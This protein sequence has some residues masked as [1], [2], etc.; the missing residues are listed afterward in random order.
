MGGGAAA[1]HAADKLA[2]VCADGTPAAWLARSLGPGSRAAACPVAQRPA[3][4][5]CPKDKLAVVRAA[6]DVLGEADVWVCSVSAFALAESLW[7]LSMFSSSL[8]SVASRS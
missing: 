5:P 6:D 4:A 1:A 8:E 2:P 7:A 3:P